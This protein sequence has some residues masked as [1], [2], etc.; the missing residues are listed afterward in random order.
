MASFQNFRLLATPITPD[1]V[2]YI[3]KQLR[4]CIIQLLENDEVNNHDEKKILQYIVKAKRW[5]PY[6][7]RHSAITADSDY[8]PDYALKKVRWSMNSKQ[9]LQ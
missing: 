8:L 2:D 4:E 6:C 5:N 9:C 1:S 7:L 3:M